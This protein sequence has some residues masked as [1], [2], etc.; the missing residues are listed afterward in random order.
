MSAEEFFSSGLEAIRAYEKETGADHGVLYRSLSETVSGEYAALYPLGEDGE[1]EMLTPRGKI[2]ARSG[3][4]IRWDWREDALEEMGR[5]EKLLGIV[6]EE[7]AERKEK[8]RPRV[9]L[10]RNSTFS[11]LEM[12]LS[13][14]RTG[15]IPSGT[16]SH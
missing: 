16:E 14:R 4:Y 3:H 7:E 6:A 15:L 8:R 13:L 11:K 10:L 2:P 12:D 5:I 9:T 1:R